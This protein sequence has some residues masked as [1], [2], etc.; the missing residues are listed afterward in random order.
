MYLAGF[1]AC[2][3][4]TERCEWQRLQVA[5][6]TSGNISTAERGLIFYPVLADKE[7]RVNYIMRALKLIATFV[8][9]ICCKH[10][11]TVS[12]KSNEVPRLSEPLLEHNSEPSNPEWFVA[13]GVGVHKSPSTQ[14]RV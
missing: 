11:H 4:Q 14:V 6:P 12:L 5:T 9:G 3:A 10:R 8:P 13:F 1:R 2:Y 7:E